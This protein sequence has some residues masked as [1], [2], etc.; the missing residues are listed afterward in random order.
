VYKE[1]VVRIQK[2]SFAVIA[3][4]FLLFFSSAFQLSVYSGTVRMILLAVLMS[5]LIVYA[6]NEKTHIRVDLFSVILF[7]IGLISYIVNFDY[8][9]SLL[10]YCI[11]MSMAIVF[12]SIVSVDLFIDAYKKV[13]YYISIGSLA[14]FALYYIAP[15]ALNLLP[16]VSNV[17]DTSAHSIL[18]AISPIDSRNY[19]LFW[20]PGA[21]QAYLILAVFL[22]IFQNDMKNKSYIIVYLIAM[23]TT[24]ST[25]GYIA[26]FEIGICVLLDFLMTKESIGKKTLIVVYSLVGVGACVLILSNTGIDIGNMV[27]GKLSI[28]LVGHK[29]LS[30]AGVRYYSLLGGIKAFIKRPLFGMGMYNYLAFLKQE[31]Q[32]ELS[33]CTWINWFAEYGVFFGAMMLKGLY[34]F[35]KRL[36]TNMIV[37]LLL[38]SSILVSISSEDFTTNPSLVIFMLYGLMEQK[39][40]FNE[41]S[42]DD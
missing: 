34:Q 35:I 28:L 22:E 12:A 37:T 8:T 30:S 11:N 36:N 10:A 25:T 33:T 39:V 3:V 21:F 23:L 41:T 40:K 14:L 17:S 1:Y 13:I 24:F 16:K 5:C 26:V 27:F 6:L 31:F 9:N 7:A 42:T 32:H 4:F 18:I 2:I 29:D 20:E 38:F 15:S 19:G